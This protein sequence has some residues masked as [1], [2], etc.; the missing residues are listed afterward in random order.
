MTNLEL[1]NQVTKTSLE[2]KMTTT[3]LHSYPLK[4]KRK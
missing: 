1:G 4:S 3:F 2:Q